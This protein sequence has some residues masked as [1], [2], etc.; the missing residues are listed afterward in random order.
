MVQCLDG[1]K[2]HTLIPRLRSK[3]IS[4]VCLTPRVTTEPFGFSGFRNRLFGP[5]RGLRFR[6]YEGAC[7]LDHGQVEGWA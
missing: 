5:G 4:L 6:F 7:G 1:S 2:A 3:F